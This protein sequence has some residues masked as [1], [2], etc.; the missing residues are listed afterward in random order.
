[1]RLPRITKPS[2]SMVVA[3]VALFV[4]LG[5]GSYAAVKLGT[6]SAKPA[7]TL[8]SGKTLKGLYRVSD[9]EG[10][11][12]QQQFADST[13]TYQQPL[14]T[15]PELHFISAGSAGV[16][17][18]PGSPQKPRA[19]PG[20]LCVYENNGGQLDPTDV[21]FLAGD[22]RD[23]LGFSLAALSAA[24]QGGFYFSEGT[25]AVTAP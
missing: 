16:L 8:K 19:L 21:A 6:E 11:A 23:K 2:P 20:H 3:T 12:N 4:A 14:K 18:C 24:N 1:M 25:W 15:A 13:V 22:T 17:E 10:S 9:F 7:G 5:G